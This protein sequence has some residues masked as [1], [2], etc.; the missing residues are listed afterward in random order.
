M[1]VKVTWG[2]ELFIRNQMKIIIQS[3]Q[4]GIGIPKT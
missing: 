2:N 1:S 4:D 3:H